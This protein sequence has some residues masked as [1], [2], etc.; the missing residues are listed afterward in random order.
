MITLNN[1]SK[2]YPNSPDLALNNINLD[3]N[4]GECIALIGRSGSGKSTL[5][6]LINRLL[7]PTQ[8]EILINNRSI[9]SFSKT[10]LQATMAF[11]FQHTCLFPHLTLQQNIA[12][13]LRA[14]GI[15]KK[16]RLQRADTLL[17]NVHLTP[18]H[19]R[20][21]HPH[22]CSG[23]EQ[24]RVGIARA[25]ITDPKILLM[26]EPFSALD[27]ITRQSL[28]EV[29]LD[30]KKIHHKT[31]VFVTHQIEEAF[32]IA[33]RIAILEQ[34]KILQFDTAQQIKNHPRCKKVVELLRASI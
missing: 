30:L 19:Y 8:G 15:S 14:R 12:L 9:H 23:G 34:G 20:M 7:P 3:I 22:E 27:Q 31:I 24:Q 2:R 5:L 28:T 10:S 4:P 29:I 21:R 11:V 6:R 32:V 26:D 1:L 33:D 16:E 13:P 25:L 18:Q 17:N